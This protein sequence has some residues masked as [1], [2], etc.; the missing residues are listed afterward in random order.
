[1]PINLLNTA[2]R[3]II[4]Y[5]PSFFAKEL[6]GNQN[7][8]GLFVNAR[9]PLNQKPSTS[10]LQNLM[11]LDPN[12]PDN[13]TKIE[14]MHHENINWFSVNFLPIDLTTDQETIIPFDNYFDHD[15]LGNWLDLKINP[16]DKFFKTNYNLIP[17][18]SVRLRLRLLP[19]RMTVRK[20]NASVGGKTI[21]TKSSVVTYL[22]QL[23]YQ[24][25]QTLTAHTDIFIRNYTDNKDY[26]NSKSNLHNFGHLIFD[27]FDLDGNFYLSNIL[28]LNPR[29]ILLNH[30]GQA[31]GELF[32]S[33]R[34]AIEK[35]LTDFVLF[36]YL[37]DLSET[38]QTKYAD[39][40]NTVMQRHMTNSRDDS[41]KFNA[42]DFLIKRANHLR[43]P[44]DQ[45]QTIY[46]FI[47]QNFINQNIIDQIL[48]SNLNLKF[49]SILQDLHKNKA[50]L[51]YCPK[52]S[53]AVD[54]KLSLEQKRAVMTS[55]P[56]TLI[57][58]GAGTGKSSVILNRI[59]Y[60]I[61]S[62]VNPRD[63]Q[64]L[65]FTNAAADHIKDLYPS[66]NSS[67]IAS[68]IAQIY[69]D[70][71]PGQAIVSART[72]ANTLSIAYGGSTKQE[73]VELLYDLNLLTEKPDRGDINLLDEG[74]RR[75]SQLIRKNPKLV[76]N[77]CRSLNET[78]LDLQILLCY[79]FLDKL[80]L[81][82]N[83]KSK[84]LLVDEVQ[85]NSIFEFMFLLR[86]TTLNNSSFFVVGDAS[87]TLYAFRN[88]N[89]RAMN[90]LESS[91]VFDLFKLETNFRS[92]QEILTYANELLTQTESNYFAQIQLHANNLRQIKAKDFT[93]NVSYLHFDPDE[94][95][96]AKE[97][98]YT[99]QNTQA[100]KEY[101]K[102]CL[103]RGENV[104]VLA[105]ARRD[106]VNLQKAFGETYHK[107]FVNIAS[108]HLDD[109][110]LF[111]GFWANL[112]DDRKNNF[113][114]ADVKQQLKLIK[115]AVL[116]ANPDPHYRITTKRDY[117]FAMDKWDDFVKT[118]SVLL[119]SLIDDNKNGKISNLNALKKLV[120][121]MLD[122]E[123]AANRKRQFSSRKANSIDKRE[124]AINNN[125]LIFSTIHSVKGLEFDNV[126]LLVKSANLDDDEAQ[127]RL[128]YVGLTRA[129]NSE[130]VL[131]VNSLPAADTLI[132]QN[133]EAA[134]NKLAKN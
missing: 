56:L 30:A 95:K 11:L 22:V 1:M 18:S 101:I 8:T 121:Y 7:G 28:T 70:N 108:R 23:S 83:T 35:Y 43:L 26:L 44:L 3:P 14:Q 9:N 98:A 124:E 104:A 60:L 6:N 97:T 79:N 89:P 114:T 81:T 38:Y 40:L 13:Y 96:D 46:N 72:F 42:I 113:A 37:S 112:S 130:L 66:I 80:T 84:F 29:D 122:Y 94:F 50:N 65:S 117:D 32:E 91:G 78:T 123:I 54:P 19:Y 74:Y 4:T 77:V 100:I 134:L 106:V 132:H 127:K 49:N 120:Q 92:R 27:A 85:D 105:W 5:L 55:G 87:Q 2:N 82:E 88:A 63:I 36:D 109:L 34:S 67:T 51:A 39:L 115:H 58:A 93:D 12:L 75:L 15:L 24:P 71:F 90:V 33:N 10:Q 17:S 61:D 118:N 131:D 41:A 48:D 86:Y 102:N 62:G 16:Q 25:K 53:A 107:E 119:D 99:V 57:E 73:M 31:I 20:T 69:Q 21:Y 47:T 128:Y 59:K 64:V 110:T 52:S 116:E 76:V 68:L 125:Q 129:K 111:S 126:I 45:Y 133:Y 103:S